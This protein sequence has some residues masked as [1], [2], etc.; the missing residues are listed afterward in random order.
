MKLQLNKSLPTAQLLAASAEKRWQ[1]EVAGI[2]T[3][4]VSVDTSRESQSMINGVVAYLT[5]AGEGVTVPYKTSTGAINLN[6]AAMVNLAL[7]VGDHVQWCFFLE[8]DAATKILATPPTIT[9][10]A[11]LDVH[12]MQ[13]PTV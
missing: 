1:K 3:G 9:T 7:H 5:H 10:L 13:T 4:G 2:T 6:L 12:Y 11:E 8:A